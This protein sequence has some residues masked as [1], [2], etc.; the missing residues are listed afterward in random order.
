[1]GLAKGVFMLETFQERKNMIMTLPPVYLTV[2]ELAQRWKRSTRTI[3]QYIADKR[4]NAVQFTERG[5]HLIPL[6]EIE[7]YEKENKV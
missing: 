7:R 1:M 3:R 4:I 2:K 5:P 6:E